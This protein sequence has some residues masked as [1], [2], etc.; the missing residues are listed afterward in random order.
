[1]IIKAISSIIQYQ[2]SRLAWENNGPRPTHYLAYQVTGRYDHTVNGKVVSVP[3]DHLLFIR[4]ED[5]YTVK[6]Y[7]KGYSICV[8]FS[9]DTD[10][11]TGVW[12]MRANPAVYNLF[13]KLLEV[14]NLE[15]ESNYY[16]AFSRLYQILSML[17]KK[18]TSPS[19]IHSPADGV[20]LAAEYVAEHLSDGEI[21]TAK[22]AELC[23]VSERYFRTLF[24]RIYNRTPTQ[25]IIELRLNTAA[26]LLSYGGF[27]VAEVAQA[28]GISDVYYFSKLFKKRFSVA[29]SKF[30]P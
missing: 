15:D 3:S 19:P 7:E 10:F 13:L 1:M 2:T 30:T 18:S 5:S 4:Q 11:S 27:T 21:K 20:K 25:Y 23:G 24:K 17:S 22:L 14:K 26:K 9:A 8:A 6:C 28:V 12:D 29:P 16:L